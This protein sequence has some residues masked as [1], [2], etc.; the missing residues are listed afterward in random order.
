MRRIVD[1]LRPAELDDLGLVHALQQQVDRF[2]DANRD[3]ALR[4]D[5]QI[6]RLSAAVDLAILRIASEALNNA[7]RHSGASHVRMI[8]VRDS[9]ELVMTIE[10]NGTG[11]DAAAHSGLGL[12]SMRERAEELG[13]TLRIDTSSNG[14]SVHARLP[15]SS[16]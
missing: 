16:R 6:D 2:R 9:R 1:D 12:V 10:D 5:G 13:G 8:L 11:I 15:V 4:F 7:A 14:T 3:V